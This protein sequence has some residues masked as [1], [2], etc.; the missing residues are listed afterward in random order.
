MGVQEDRE[1][2]DVFRHDAMS[3]GPQPPGDAGCWIEVP[4]A[5]H[6]EPRMAG[7]LIGR[8]CGL[9]GAE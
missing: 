1:G 7:R 4:H 3:A 5:G 6:G 2:V 9:G 8:T